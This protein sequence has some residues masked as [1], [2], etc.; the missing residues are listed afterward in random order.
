MYLLAGALV[1][2]YFTMNLLV[3]RQPTFDKKIELAIV[4]TC[5]GVIVGC[6]IV[7]DFM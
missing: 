5:T 4:S 3:R 2:S 7:D 6:A 1:G